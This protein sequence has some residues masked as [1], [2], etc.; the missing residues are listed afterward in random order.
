MP[1]DI[2]LSEKK[3]TGLQITFEGLF[4]VSAPT[5]MPGYIEI[6]K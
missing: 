2:V 1:G 6:E 5:T 4:T 3:E